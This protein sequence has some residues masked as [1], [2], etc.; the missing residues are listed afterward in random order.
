MMIFRKKQKNTPPPRTP[1][2]PQASPVFSYYSNRPSDISREGETRGEQA[3]Q[4]SRLQKWRYIPSYAAL[5]GITVSLVY[6]STLS[7]QPRIIIQDKAAAAVLRDP[8]DY[9]A[10]ARDL[11]AG[12]LLNRSKITINTASLS[13]AMQKRF[14]ELRSVTVTL[15]VAS[16]RPVIAVRP[17][18]PALILVSQGNAYVVD[19]DGRAILT[20]SEPAGTAIPELPVVRD[21]SGLDVEVGKTVLPKQSTEYIVTVLAQLQAKQLQPESLTLP[22]LANE[23]HVRLRGQPYYVKFN[24]AGDPRIAAG[25]FLAVKQRL[26]AETQ[27]PGEYIDVRVDE[28][29]YYR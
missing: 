1:R 8:S 11:L 17:A 4:P 7:T 24:T 10:A 22:A 3:V 14:P 2:A 28:R 18:R 16:R 29:A 12:S 13:R 27:L 25:T 21:E 9:E 15:P 23:L 19:S 6:L 20:E 26:E 5:L